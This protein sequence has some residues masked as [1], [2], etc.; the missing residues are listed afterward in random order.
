MDS[1][2]LALGSRKPTANFPYSQQPPEPLPAHLAHFKS[3]VM[4]QRSLK[5]PC[6][7]RRLL[8]ARRRQLCNYGCCMIVIILTPWA[9]WLTKLAAKFSGSLQPAM[10]G[11]LPRKVAAGLITSEKKQ[12]GVIA[13]KG[14]WRP[15][16]TGGG[17][18]YC[19]GK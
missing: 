14:V 9:Q 13:G 10:A 12:I 7:L 11:L 8:Q 19:L 5:G 4:R 3:L 2:R 16:A 15:G 18:F 1:W 17:K 6:T